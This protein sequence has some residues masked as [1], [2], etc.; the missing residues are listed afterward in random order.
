MSKTI[1]CVVNGQ[2]HVID[3][4]GGE[5]LLEMLQD[6][7]G[8]TSVKKECETGECGACTVLVDDIPIDS[9]LYL[10]VWVD[11]KEVLTIEGLAGAGLAGYAHITWEVKRQ[12]KK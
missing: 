5:T 8:L 2:K 1:T 11:G 4:I 6:K 10:A 7:L 9:C 3:I 12:P